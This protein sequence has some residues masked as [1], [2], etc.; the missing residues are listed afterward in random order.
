MCANL[1]LVSTP[2]IS[3]Q[4]LSLS[5][6]LFYSIPFH[7]IQ[8]ILFYSIL[9]YSIQSILFYSTLLKN[10]RA[11]QIHKKKIMDELFVFASP[12]NAS[13]K[14]SLVCEMRF[15]TVVR[16]YQN[17]CQKVCEKC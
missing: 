1:Q 14:E 10:Y 15:V 6:Q 5:V 2:L 17:L 16:D 7:F 9:F 3:I 8:S 12:C 11:Y 13:A 4:R